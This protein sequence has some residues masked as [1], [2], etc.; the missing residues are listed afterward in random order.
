MTELA[1]PTK[2]PR[3][4]IEPEPSLPSPPRRE[5]PE[6]D[7]P[8]VPFSRPDRENLPTETPAINPHKNPRRPGCR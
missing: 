8:G 6:E 2:T 5:A 3:R 4:K 7:H 1:T